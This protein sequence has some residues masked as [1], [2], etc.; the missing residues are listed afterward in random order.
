MLRMAQGGVV[1]GVWQGCTAAAR[2]VANRGGA[3]TGGE[4]VS[5]WHLPSS[6]GARALLESVA[7]EKKYSVPNW[8]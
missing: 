5:C 7:V 1:V 2:L 8:A 4:C 3:L 6:L